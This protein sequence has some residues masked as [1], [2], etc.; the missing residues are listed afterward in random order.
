MDMFLLK[1]TSLIVCRGK[2]S[3]KTNDFVELLVAQFD[4]RYRSTIYFENAHFV[5][6]V[7]YIFYFN[8][9]LPRKFLLANKDKDVFLDILF[10]QTH[11]KSKN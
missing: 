10:H 6:A 11:Y 3:E 2:H 8:I 5:R 9:I 4:P 1:L 7:R